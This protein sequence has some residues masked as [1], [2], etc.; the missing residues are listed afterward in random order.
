M[1][2]TG[3]NFLSWQGKLRSIRKNLV[4]IRVIDKNGAMDVPAIRKI[5]EETE[6]EMNGKVES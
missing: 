1:K 5:V 3:K 4:N 2:Q 6:A